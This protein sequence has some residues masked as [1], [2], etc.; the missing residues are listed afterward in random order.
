MLAVD[1]ACKRILPASARVDLRMPI[2]SRRQIRL[3]DVNRSGAIA[4]MS[5]ASTRLGGV[6]SRRR[7][8][9]RITAKRRHWPKNVERLC[10]TELA[11]LGES[12]GAVQLEIFA[13]VEMA[14]LIKMIVYG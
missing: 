4:T 7:G 3:R 10:G 11:P 2:G 9:V 8:I 12:S 1:N 13:A 6:G 5:E 14:L